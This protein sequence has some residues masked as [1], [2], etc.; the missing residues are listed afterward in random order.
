M[1]E[2]KSKGKASKLKPSKKVKEPKA[3]ANEDLKE[4]ER[5]T[6]I[7]SHRASNPK[8]NSKLQKSHSESEEES[9][10]KPNLK[11]TEMSG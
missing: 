4:T 7:Y 1:A 3:S 11:S 9:T 8:E 10:I 2:G 6:T 5:P